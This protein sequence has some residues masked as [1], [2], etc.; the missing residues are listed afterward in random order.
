MVLQKPSRAETI[1]SLVSGFAALLIAWVTV[2]WQTARVAR[3]NP[4]EVLQR[5]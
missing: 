3:A 1:R 4:A 2:G 5:E